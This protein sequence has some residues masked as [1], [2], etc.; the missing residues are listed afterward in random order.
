MEADQKRIYV[1]LFNTESRQK[2]KLIPN[3]PLRIYTCGPTV[4]DYAHIGNFRT[5]IFEDILR[6]TLKLMHF[7]IGRAHV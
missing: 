6:K 4:Y 2:E 1:K 5:Y 7:E 3:H